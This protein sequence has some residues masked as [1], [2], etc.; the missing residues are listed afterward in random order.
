[1]P[2]PAAV[3]FVDEDSRA[4]E[5]RLSSRQERTALYT[6]LCCLAARL[7][8][9]VAHG[10]TLVVIFVSLNEITTGQANWWLMFLP[11]WVGC[12]SCTLL[13]MIA[14]CASC[15]YI[16]LCL[17]ERQ[18]RLNDNPSILTEVLPE[19]VLTIPGL[20]FLVLAFCSEYHVCQYL[21]AAQAGAESSPTGLTT[22]LIMVSLL[23]LCQGA[24]FKD[25]SALWLSLGAGLLTSAICFAA[26]RKSSAQQALVVAPFVFVV[27]CLLL[28]SV[29]RLKQ[30][31]A[32]LR[33]DEKTLLQTEACLLGI[34]GV[35]LVSVTYKVSVDKLKE[36]S[37][38]GCSS[39]ILLCLLALPRA[40]LCI[41]EAQ[42]G[43]LEDRT[44][45]GQARI[46]VGSSE[47]QIGMAEPALAAS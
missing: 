28:A 15:P 34:L 18:P 1:M 21:T 43:L 39:G 32:V 24:L 3:A 5:L 2:L 29:H 16:K 10:L 25:N 12:A 8:F 47:V 41:W 7:A 4:R 17:S 19:I 36:A 33:A 40:Q 26:T 46:S 20:L 14:W 37:P 6:F 22:L 42:R 27:A 13:L 35:C 30:Y 44:F 31:A 38:E 45:S 11:I 9:L 23:S